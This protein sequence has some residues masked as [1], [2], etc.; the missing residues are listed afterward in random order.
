MEKEDFSN[1]NFISAPIHKDFYFNK[2]LE[3]PTVIKE[4]PEIERI[5]TA[6]KFIACITVQVAQ[7]QQIEYQY[8]SLIYSDLL[9]KISDML[10]TVKKNF[11]RDEDIFLVDLHDV[12][13]F[14]IFFCISINLSGSDLNSD[15]CFLKTFISS[16]ISFNLT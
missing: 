15:C 16:L 2:Y 10:K 3:I 14:I 4:Y 6:S 1:S 5:L 12:D 8:G 9:V 11:F 13:T 7:L